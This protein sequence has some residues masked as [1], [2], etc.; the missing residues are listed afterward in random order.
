MGHTP[1]RPTPFRKGNCI[2]IDSGAVFPS[3][4]LS[5][6]EVGHELHCHQARL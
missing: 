5:V 4:Y 2:W 3:G 6:L 1:I